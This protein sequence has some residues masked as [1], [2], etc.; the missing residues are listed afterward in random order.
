MATAP[1][2]LPLTDAAS[3]RRLTSAADVARALGELAVRE[4]A[5][6]ARLESLLTGRADVERALAKLGDETG[7]VRID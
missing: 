3:T 4:R 1:P 6:D 2:S 7:E 5:I